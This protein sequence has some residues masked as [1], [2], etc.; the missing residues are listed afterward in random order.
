MAGGY[1]TRQIKFVSDNFLSEMNKFVFKLLL[2]LMLFFN[3]QS[4]FGAQFDNSKLLLGAALAILLIVLLSICFVPL[5]VRKRSQQGSIIQAIYRSNFLIYGI[6]LASGL[7][8]S[9]AVAYISLMMAFMI[10]IFNILAVI[11]LSIYSESNTR[12]VNI[13]SISTDIIKNPLII[14]CFGGMAAAI[15]HIDI[16]NF[17]A[18]P[19]SE[20][21][22]M[23]GP[24]ALFV[25]GGQFRF[26]SLQNN[27]VKV[28]STS[29]L[30]LIIVPVVCLCIF[31]QL[32]YRDAELAVFLCLFATPTA[33]S[34]YIMA[35]NMGCDG[36]LAGQ[37]VVMTTIC[38]SVT[39]F[40]FIFFLRMFGYL[41]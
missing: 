38:S 10:P 31:I 23:G 2:P 16:P 36:E 41:N 29:L 15:F 26:K 12:G 28:A 9:E 39:I 1:F 11:I 13:K 27:I 14:G 19:L 40:A 4:S 25:M 17:A 21:A 30:R 24:L 32:G 20:F 3:I 37:I 34:S 6:P 8:G 33:V 7:Y 35:E 5:F 18:A 22:N